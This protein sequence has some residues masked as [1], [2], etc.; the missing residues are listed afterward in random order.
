MMSAEDSKK[1]KGVSTACDESKG[2]SKIMLEEKGLSVQRQ[3]WL[4]YV[5]EQKNWW[6]RFTPEL[7]MYVNYA[8]TY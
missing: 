5:I 4:Y 6:R 2:K 3:P 1:P 8:V 7:T